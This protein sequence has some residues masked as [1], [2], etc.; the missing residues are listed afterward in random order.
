M[1]QSHVSNL[2]VGLFHLQGVISMYDDKNPNSNRSEEER[3]EANR[4]DLGGPSW[5]ESMQQGQQEYN[6]QR[7]EYEAQL[8]ETLSSAIQR[9][10]IPDIRN[11]PDYDAV[12]GEHERL[13]FLNILENPSQQLGGAR[14]LDT[15]YSDDD[16]RRA[17]RR[18]Q[19]SIE[20]LRRDRWHKAYDYAVSKGLLPSPESIDPDLYRRYYLEAFKKPLA[21]IPEYLQVWERVKTEWNASQTAAYTE[22][23]TAQ[24]LK[25]RHPKIRTERDL[26]LY[27]LIYYA[28]TR[29]KPRVSQKVACSKT[30][31]NQRTYQKKKKTPE[32]FF[33]DAEIQQLGVDYE[34]LWKVVA[35]GGDIEDILET[36]F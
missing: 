4:P 24:A 13:C 26:L 8:S 20:E 28:S 12:K 23:A 32:M 5:H 34:E 25:L 17:W 11:L 9:G 7:H 2:A 30:G 31:V 3:R 36:D 29:M 10:V 14:P 6:Q 1:P 18:T 15:V 21:P 19:E 33:S 35:A 27:S 22:S 16:L